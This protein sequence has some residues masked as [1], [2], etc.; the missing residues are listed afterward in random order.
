MQR[1]AKA[2][3]SVEGDESPMKKQDT[4]FTQEAMKPR[5]KRGPFLILSITIPTSIT[6]KDFQVSMLLPA[7]EQVF[8]YA[9]QPPTFLTL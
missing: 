7:G 9:S 6:E 8:L 1:H 5:G 3:I 2:C 4:A